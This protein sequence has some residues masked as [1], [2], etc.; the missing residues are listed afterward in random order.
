M[1]SGRIGPTTSVSDINCPGGRRPRAPRMLAGYAFT[2]PNAPGRTT[3][4]L[5]VDETLRRIVVLYRV[6]GWAWMVI[7]V[8]LTPGDD[9]RA[10]MAIAGGALALATLWMATTMWAAG[11]SAQLGRTWFVL[12]DVAVTLVVASASTAAGADELFHGGYPMSTLAV[13]AYAFNLRMALVAAGVLAANQVVVHAIDDRGVLPAV[14]SVVFV[15]FA[16]MLG[17]AFDNLRSQERSRLAVQHELNDVNDARIRHEERI[18]LANRLHD[19]V[20]Q[21]LNVIQRDAEDPGQVRYL[22]R[23]QERQLR[24]TISEYRSPYTCSARAELQ[25]ICDDV[26]DLHRIAIQSVIRGDADCDE[27]LRS[28]LAATREALL[29]AAKHSGEDVVDLYAELG[30]PKLRLFIRDRGRGFDP[31]TV[32]TGRGLDHSLRKR[33]EDVGATVSVKSSPGDGT[34]VEIVWE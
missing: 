6:L 27:R 23:R 20:L 25:T 30:P 14:G 29:N 33:I 7:L 15:V 4:D 2:M 11:N 22:A 26:E 34:E 13:T 31:A 28:L 5:P 19:S 21:T 1:W 18:E 32:A 24:R 8:I 12:V 17:W 10:N 3:H 9:P 16:I